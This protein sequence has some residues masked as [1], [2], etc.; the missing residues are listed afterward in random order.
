RLMAF[1]RVVL[2]EYPRQGSWSLGLVT[3]GAMRRVEETTRERCVTVFTPS[4]PTPFTGFA[5]V[6]PES[7]VIDLP[8]SI[9]EAI[10]FVLT[11]GVLIP[12]SQATGPV[13]TLNP[14]AGASGERT[15]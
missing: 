8:I 1:K 4:T 9:D 3:A 10:R 13:R 5:I 15:A 7:Q 2:V 14:P 12:E 11:G 6:V